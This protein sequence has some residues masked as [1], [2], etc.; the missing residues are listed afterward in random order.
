[1]NVCTTI[2]SA[3]INVRGNLIDPDT[4]EKDPGFKFCFDYQSQKVRKF[5]RD[6][7]GNRLPFCSDIGEVR[8]PDGTARKYVYIDP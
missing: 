4:N 3:S 5:A 2:P 8:C 6:L 1:M 7:E